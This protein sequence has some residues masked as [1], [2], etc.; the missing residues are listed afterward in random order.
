MRPPKRWTN[1]VL[2]AVL[3]IAFTTGWLAFFYDSAPSRWS[4]ILHASSGY[5]ILALTPWKSVMRRVASSGAAQAG[6][7]P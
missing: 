5:A 7:S 3:G 4:L 2:F 1:Q 6:G